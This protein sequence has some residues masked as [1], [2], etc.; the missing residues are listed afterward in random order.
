MNLK[1]SKTISLIS[2]IGLYLIGSILVFLSNQRLP[3]FK[4][5]DNIH[6][7]FWTESAFQ[8]RYAVISPPLKIIVPTEEAVISTSTV[9]ISGRTDPN[10][11]VLIDDQSVSVMQDGTFKKEIT[12]FPGKTDVKISAVNR[13][14]KQTTIVR[15]IEVK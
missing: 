4:Y 5:Q 7:L 3:N 10:S 6:P 14:G 8:Y 13:F 11:T 9:T 15:H 2:V 1:L 12:V